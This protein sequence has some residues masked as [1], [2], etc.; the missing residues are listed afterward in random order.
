MRTNAILN[1]LVVL[2]PV[3]ELE[4]SELEE[5]EEEDEDEEGAEDPSTFTRPRS[6]LYSGN[7]PTKSDT[8]RR[9]FVSGVNGKVPYLMLRAS[10]HTRIASMG[11]DSNASASGGVPALRR[12][13]ISITARCVEG[14][15][16]SNVSSKIGSPCR[17]L[18]GSMES[19]ALRSRD[20]KPHMSCI[21]S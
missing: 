11:H 9:K 10:P 20:V 3:V 18:K 4:E 16:A 15:E 12:R 6:G 21:F 1:V 2:A 5:E 17:A 7:A 14:A 13:H 8:T 19:A